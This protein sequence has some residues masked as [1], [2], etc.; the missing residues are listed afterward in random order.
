MNAT[1]EF[2]LDG[3]ERYCFW[4][5]HSANEIGARA[6]LIG[7]RPSFRTRAE[8]DMEAAEAALETALAAVKTARAAF[9]AIP[10]EEQVA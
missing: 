8:A 6:R 3:I 4:V 2:Y 1:T 5:T 9:A 10:Q 7:P